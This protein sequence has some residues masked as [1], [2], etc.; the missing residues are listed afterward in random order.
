MVPGWTSCLPRR[1]WRRL[2]S[3]SRWGKFF[4][5]GNEYRIALLFDEENVDAQAGRVRMEREMGAQEQLNHAEWLRLRGRF[6]EARVALDEGRELT[7]VQTDAFDSG[8]IDID[9]D[10]YILLYDEALRLERD[11]RY[12]HAIE[13][14]DK[15][16]DVAGY[17][18]DAITRRSTLHGFVVQ[19][20]DLYSRAMAAADADE[21][22]A[23]LSQIELIW[24]EYRDVGQRL[25]ELG[26]E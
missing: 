25:R 17:Y 10:Q 18:E 8:A 24:P 15:L 7:D 4:A 5:A 19:T 14:Y 13:A 16:L 3:S 1:A 21:E 2:T 26:A 23:L 11:F 20:K 9:Q 22:I 6:D 12:G